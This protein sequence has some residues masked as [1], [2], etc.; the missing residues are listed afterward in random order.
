MNYLRDVT[1]HQPHPGPTVR[2]RFP[3]IGPIGSPLERLQDVYRR[4]CLRAIQ[5]GKAD[6]AAFHAM[7]LAHTR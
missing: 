6:M 4:C 5:D 3:E 7:M 2:V 1:E